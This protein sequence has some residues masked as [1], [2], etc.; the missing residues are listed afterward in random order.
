MKKIFLLCS[1]IALFFMNNGLAQATKQQPKSG[2][3]ILEH[4]LQKMKANLSLTEKQ[5][6]KLRTDNVEFAKRLEAYRTT[7]RAAKKANMEELQK[8]IDASMKKHLT[9]KQ[10][11][12][13]VATRKRLMK[14]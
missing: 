12:E 7:D 8:D 4:R 13:L 6:K 14:N 11:T 2:Q 5:V 3:E 1:F 9:K 10:Y